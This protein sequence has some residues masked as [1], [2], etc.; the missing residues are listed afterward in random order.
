M[1]KNQ[2]HQSKNNYSNLEDSDQV[3]VNNSYQMAIFKKRIIWK[4]SIFAMKIV[5]PVL[6]FI[7]IIYLFFFN[8]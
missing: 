1:S 4:A 2:N 5:I 8:N 3:D 6:I 7:G